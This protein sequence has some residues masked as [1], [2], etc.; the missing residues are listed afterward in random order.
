M[1]IMDVFI[2][3][4]IDYSFNYC[5]GSISLIFIHQIL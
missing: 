2:K 4:E 3:M 5:F 1:E